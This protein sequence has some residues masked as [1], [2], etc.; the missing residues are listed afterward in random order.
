MMALLNRITVLGFNWITAVVLFVF[1]ALSISTNV[2]SSSLP[3]QNILD[4]TARDIDQRLRDQQAIQN[5]LLPENA[6]KQTLNSNEPQVSKVAEG[7]PCFNIQQTQ[8]VDDSNLL[9]IPENV[10]KLNGTC[11]DKKALVELVE[12]INVFY[13]KEGLITTR[14]YLKPQNLK[15]GKLVLVAKAGVLQSFKLADGS[16]VNTKINNAY[17]FEKGEV[18]SLRKMEQG[19]DNLNRLKS[20]SA[21]TQLQPGDELGQSIIEVSLKNEKPWRFDLGFNNHGVESTGI[22]NA[23]ASFEFDN[24]LNMNDDLAINYNQNT[25]SDS[26]RK[27]NRSTSFNYNIPYKNWL[28]KLSSSHYS[29]NRIIQGINQ[30]YK[31][32][33]FSRNNRLSTEKLI[34][35]N[36][37][38]RVYWAASL[39]LKTSRN[40]IEDT[41]IETQYP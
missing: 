25:D 1:T 41:E 39:N 29:Y 35:R 4:Q 9:P 6:P 8:L 15:Q 32:D 26:A 19:L 17:P 22:H 23:S 2:Y 36:Q 31:I 40:Y 11:A 13:Q 12:S 28:F 33:G 10:Q 30:E 16:A 3:S 37:Q 5:S 21:K 34:H 14:V 7:G 27:R 18:V 24:L 20:Q 38:S